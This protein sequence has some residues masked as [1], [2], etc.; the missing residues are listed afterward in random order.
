MPYAVKMALYD[1]CA[2]ISLHSPLERKGP[3]TFLCQKSLGVL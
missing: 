1:K 2:C 3:K